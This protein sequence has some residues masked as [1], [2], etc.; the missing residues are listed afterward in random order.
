MAVPVSSDAK[1][2]VTDAKSAKA[3]A[4]RDMENLIGWHSGRIVKQVG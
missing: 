3:R 2:K 4:K 1:V